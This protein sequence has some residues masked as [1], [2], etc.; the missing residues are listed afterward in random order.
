MN[1]CM[2]KVIGRLE[3][4]ER[5]MISSKNTY[6]ESIKTTKRTVNQYIKYDFLVSSIPHDFGITI[7]ILM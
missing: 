4:V 6:I 3:Q 2:I 5:G 1:T 7:T